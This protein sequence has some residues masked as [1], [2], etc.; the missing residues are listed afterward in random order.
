MREIFDP[1]VEFALDERRRRLE[2][3]ARRELLHQIGAKLP[4][5]RM[6]RFMLQVLAHADAQRVERVELSQIFRELIVELGE[7]APLEALHRHGIR[8]VGVRQ[9]PNRVVGGIVDA[10]GLGRANSE[11]QE[12]LVEPRRV[13]LGAE[14]DADI[15]VL[16]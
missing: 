16:F 8:D 6:P 7:D 1:A 4:L 11:P 13:G 10:E 3:H 2:W 12:L 14:F 15:L 9:L 5:G